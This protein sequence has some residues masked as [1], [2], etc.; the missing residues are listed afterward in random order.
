MKKH[1]WDGENIKLNEESK[2]NLIYI[3][4]IINKII[5]IKYNRLNLIK[6]SEDTSDDNI[7]NDFRL[8]GYYY[9]KHLLEILQ[10]CI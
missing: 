9:G 1:L 10:T 3:I 2:L 4:I 8:N 5:N 7:R 6:F